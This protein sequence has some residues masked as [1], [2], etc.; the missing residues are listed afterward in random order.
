MVRSA[1]LALAVAAACRCDPALASTA[2]V[3]PDPER[4]TS[5]LQ[6]V[7]AAGERNDVAV[8]ERLETVTE[9]ERVLVSDAQGVTAG[10]G[11]RQ[12]DATSAVCRPSR[13][14]IARVSLGDLDDRLSMRTRQFGGI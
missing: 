7:A 12:L 4:D 13:D 10:S 3:G 6:V 14:V 1:V 11:C 9:N 5:T 2:F 8:T